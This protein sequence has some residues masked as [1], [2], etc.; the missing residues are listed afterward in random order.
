MS[1]RKLV[2]ETEQ[3]IGEIFYWGYRHVNGKIIVKRFFDHQ[4]LIDALKS[5]FV[6]DYDGPISA[7][8]IEEAR[9]FFESSLKIA[10]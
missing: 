8:N 1:T 6:D 10:G 2:V 7:K 9:E 4:D 3:E 5:D